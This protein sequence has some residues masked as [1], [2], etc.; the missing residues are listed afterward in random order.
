MSCRTTRGQN[1]CLTR[2]IPRGP[3]EKPLFLNSLV[4]DFNTSAAAAETKLSCGVMC[5]TPGLYQ[6]HPCQLGQSGVLLTVMR[7]IVCVGVVD[8]DYHHQ[9]PVQDEV[10][11][12][13][14]VVIQDSLAKDEGTLCLVHLVHFE[15]VA[16]MVNWTCSPA[17]G[18]LMHPGGR[19][20]PRS[21]Y[22][23]Y[24][25]LNSHHLEL[26]RVQLPCLGGESCDAAPSAPR[27]ELNNASAPPAA[28]PTALAGMIACPQGSPDA[29]PRCPDACSCPTRF[30]TLCS[31][32]EGR[33]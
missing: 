2:W 23:P 30:R 18:D 8:V 12:W 29:P 26:L 19:T 7:L 27:A 14:L 13:I 10:F 3:I 16:V 22:G 24:H 31:G 5:L 28:S 1:D 6:V 20:Y 9:C 25:C 21:G 32:S 33:I 4:F 17:D 11:C 15:S